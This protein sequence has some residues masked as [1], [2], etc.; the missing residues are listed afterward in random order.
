MMYMVCAH[1]QYFSTEHPVQP[2]WLKT[3]IACHKLQER[4]Q[5]SSYKRF[6]WVHTS[7]NAHA[8]R[9]IFISA[10]ST[11]RLI[12]KINLS[13]IYC[14]DVLLIIVDST[15]CSPFLFRPQESKPASLEEGWSMDG[16]FYCILLVTH[17][18]FQF[19]TGFWILVISV[20]IGFHYL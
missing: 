5:R 18:F 17:A 11:L 14:E 4:A 13:S 20:Y 6:T 8:F 3:F 12:L 16:A 1:I 19:L 2:T 15:L 9:I 10:R 7:V